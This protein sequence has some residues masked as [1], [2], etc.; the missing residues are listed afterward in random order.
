VPSPCRLTESRYS[1]PG[2]VAL[3]A[4]LGREGMTVRGLAR[5]AGVST[6]TIGALSAGTLREPSLSLAL[7]LERICGIDVHAWR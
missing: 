4:Y 1:T 5:R 6:G 7:A 2:H 3:R